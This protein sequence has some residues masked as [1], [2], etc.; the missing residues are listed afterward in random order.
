VQSVY[1]IGKAPLGWVIH[2]DGVK[3][4]GVYGSKMAALEAATVAATF[5]VRA[6]IGIQINVPST[7]E[8]EEMPGNWIASLK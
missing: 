7:A 8:P 3:I 6:G 5:D 1:N 4:G 2:R